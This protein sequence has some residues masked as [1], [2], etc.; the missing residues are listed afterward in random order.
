MT[1]ETKSTPIINSIGSFQLTKRL[2]TKA[3]VSEIKFG[4]SAIVEEP[5]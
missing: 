5:I 4:G 2:P 1:V 3:N